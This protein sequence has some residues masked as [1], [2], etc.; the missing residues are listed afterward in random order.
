MSEREK[1]YQ[2]LDTVPDTKISYIIGY[3]QGLTTEDNDLPNEETIEAMKESDEI[4]RNGSGQRFAGSTAD[5]LK[6]MLEE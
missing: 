2:L 3:I 4:I 6:M 5:F 1:L